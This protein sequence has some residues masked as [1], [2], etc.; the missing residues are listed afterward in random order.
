MGLFGTHK[1]SRG[2]TDEAVG[3]VQMFFRHREMDPGKHELEGSEGCGWWLVEGSAKV[4]IFVQDSPNGALLRITS[5]IILL[6]AGNREPIYRH[7]LDLNTN[8][9]NCA[10][11]THEDIV[12]VVA[13][14]PTL[15]LIQDEFDELIWSVAY[16]ADLLDNKLAA[17]FGV[18]LYTDDTTG[19]S[20]ASLN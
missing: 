17:K 4:Y 10:L 12:L 3:M 2:H 1:V 15:G 14:R 18:K 19:N 20:R 8:L 5:P 9:T 6:P 13:Q 16:V 7:L 11:A